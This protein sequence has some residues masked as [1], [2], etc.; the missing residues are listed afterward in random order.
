VTE[1][2]KTDKIK[3]KCYMGTKANKICANECPCLK[4]QLDL[5]SDIYDLYVS[6]L[7]VHI[8]KLLEVGLVKR[9]R[10]RV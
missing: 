9:V 8:G 7:A 10:V 4:T 3:L 6:D 1:I 5:V 2:T